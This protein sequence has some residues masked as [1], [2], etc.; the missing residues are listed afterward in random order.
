MQNCLITEQLAYDQDHLQE[1][2]NRGVLTL[3]ADQCAAYDKVLESCQ[4]G[5]GQTFFLHS[6]GGCGKTYVCKLIAATVRSMSKIALCVASS[7]IASTLLPGC[8]TA[9]SQFKIP[10]AIHEESLCNIKK[11][12]PLHCLLQQTALII[13]DEVPM[14]HRYALE[15]CD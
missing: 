14:Q 7:G 3:T 13:W 8:H 2:V 1:V 5:D 6:A 12:D 4:L 10:I 11:G 9:H 15:C